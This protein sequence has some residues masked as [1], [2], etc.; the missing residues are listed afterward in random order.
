MIEAAYLFLII[1]SITY[2]VLVSNGVNKASIFNRQKV[3][4]ILL[5]TFDF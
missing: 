3:Y 2:S 5:L 1:G 4:W